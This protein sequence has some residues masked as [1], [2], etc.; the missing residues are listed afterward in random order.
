ML[1]RPL[2]EDEARLLSRCAHVLLQS[3]GS[4]RDEALQF[5]E[6]A[7][8]AGDSDAQ[9]SFGLWLAKM[10]AL[11]ERNAGVARPAKYKDAMRWL[12]LAAEQGQKKAWYAIS[13]IYA[14]TEFSQR[15]LAE[16]RHYLNKAAE[17]GYVVAQRELGTL[18][19]RSRKSDPSNDVRAACWLQKAA[20]QNCAEARALLKKITCRPEPAAWAQAVQSH[21]MRDGAKAPQ[22][23]MARISLAAS[24]GLSR[25]EALL[26][27]PGS[28]DCGHCLL[29]DVRAQYAR[30]RRRLILVEAGT[31]RQTLDDIVRS[32]EGMDCGPNGPEG[33]Y[34]QRLYRFKKWVPD[35]AALK[36][37]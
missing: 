18:L 26:I 19:W 34:R 20:S 29:I 21:W 13:R 24:F 22:V 7:A 11:G 15:N 10:D 3:A 33:N 14:K 9:L 5:L 17:A 4:N 1:T 23:L 6:C 25:S 16:A 37:Y 27:D 36:D 2:S 32:L 28:A 31:E 12:I 30:A 35:G 8:V